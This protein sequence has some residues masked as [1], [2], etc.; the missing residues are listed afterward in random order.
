VAALVHVCQQPW[1]D[2]DEKMRKATAARKRYAA[3]R[4][5]A[6][7][8]RFRREADQ[9]EHPAAIAVAAAAPADDESEDRE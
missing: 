6:K 8:D 2:Q 4:H 3:E 1:M 5:E 7:A 9:L